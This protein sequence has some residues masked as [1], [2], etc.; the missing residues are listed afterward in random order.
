[1]SVT[2]ARA[3]SHLLAL[4]RLTQLLYFNITLLLLLGCVDIFH[5]LKYTQSQQMHRIFPLIPSTYN[6][7]LR[8]GDKDNS[9]KS[10]S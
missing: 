7:Y 6:F 8:Y 3:H 9:H 10:V 2:D 4:S 5:S 1:M